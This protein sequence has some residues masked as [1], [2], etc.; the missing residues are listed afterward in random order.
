MD[1]CIFCRIVK[2]DLPSVKVHEDERH[3]AFLDLYPAKKGHTLVIP[4]SH[5]VHFSE[6]PDTELGELI[7]FARKVAAS[8]KTALGAD[9]I[10]L[11]LNEGGAAGQLVFHVHFHVIPRFSGD[12]ILFKYGRENYSEGEMAKYGL[13]ISSSFK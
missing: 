6:M 4:K 13:K 1:E 9:G 7:S 2:G 10:N 3:L 5:S 8:V 12:G 11:F